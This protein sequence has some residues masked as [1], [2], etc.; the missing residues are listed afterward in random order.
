MRHLLAFLTLAAGGAGHAGLAL[1]QEALSGPEFDARTLGRTFLFSTQGETYGG[2][3]YLPGQRVRWSFLDGR[4][5]DGYWYEE[6]GQICFSY[7]DDSGPHCWIF[8]NEGGELSARFA[9]DPQ[10]SGFYATSESNEPL[11]CLG[12]EVGV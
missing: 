4:C 8:Y 10:G 11:L 7:D 1:A 6:G 12:P 2:E 5:K 3:E 9:G